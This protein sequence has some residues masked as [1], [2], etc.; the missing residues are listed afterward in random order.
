VV[1]VGWLVALGAWL[2][3]VG[4]L[5][6]APLSTMQAVISGGLVLLAP[7]FGTADIAIERLAHVALTHLMLLVNP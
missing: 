4:A 1:D 5:S 6:L 2:L 3:H 7:L